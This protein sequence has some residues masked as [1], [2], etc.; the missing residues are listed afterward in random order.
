M[1]PDVQL[2]IARVRSTSE[3][4]AGLPARDVAI[5]EIEDA[6]CEGYAEALAG[7]AWLTDNE[8]RLHE[9]IDDASLAVRGRELRL[10]A[11]AH[12]EFQCGV[13]ELRRELAELRRQHDRVRSGSRA[14]AP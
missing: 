13:I 9:L 14:T 10:L 2:A 12:A 1:C 4:L 5:Q 8:R 7:D 6:L 3:R 11:R